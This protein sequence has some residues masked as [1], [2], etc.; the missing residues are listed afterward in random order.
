MMPTVPLILFSL[1][2]NYL[3]EEEARSAGISAQVSKSEPA[4]ILI[5]KARC[6]L[7]Q[8]AA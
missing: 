2:T 4:A 1:Y 8:A 5:D 7:H 6:L 3:G